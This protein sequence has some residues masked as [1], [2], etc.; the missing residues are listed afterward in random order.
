M[1][2]LNALNRRD[3]APWASQVAPTLRSDYPGAPGLDAAAAR[4]YNEQYLRAFSDLHFR[5]EREVNAGDVQVVLWEATGTHDGP[6]T[7]PTGDVPAT[8]RRG[9]VRGVFIC[10]WRDGRVCREESFW[11]QI[12]LLQQL[13]LA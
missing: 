2:L 11:N 12:E 4:A 6:L 13:G 9:R 8:G 10:E 7:L 5:V 1:P 3:F